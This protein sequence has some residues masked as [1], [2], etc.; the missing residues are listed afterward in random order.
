MGTMNNDV[1][2]VLATK[3]D[4]TLVAGGTMLSA[5]LAD[6]AF[7]V[8]N[9]ETNEALAAGAVAGVRTVYLAIGRPNGKIDK[10][11]GQNIQL[12][13]VTSYTVRNYNP[14]RPQIFEI[15][16]VVPACDTEYVIKL[17][18]TNQKI[19]RRQGY[20]QYTQNVVFKT[21]VCPTGVTSSDLN[22]WTRL[23][24]SALEVDDKEGTFLVEFVTIDAIT[25]AT[26]GVAAN[27]SAGDV[28]L[29]ADVTAMDVYNA[30]NPG[31]A[32]F[33]RPRVS[34][35]E[36]E[37]ENFAGAINTNYFNPRTTVVTPSLVLG[38]EVDG[39]ITNIQ[40]AASEEGSGYDIKQL[41]YKASSWNGSV[42]PYKVN[43]A[44]GLEK[45]GFVF[46]STET[47]TYAQ[48]ILTSNFE[49][50]SGWKEYSNPI[51]T[52]IAVPSSNEAFLTAL[53]GLLDD[54]VG[55]QGFDELADDYAAFDKDEATVESTSDIDDV[56]T[57]GLG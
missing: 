29:E 6:G 32:V 33:V 3:S 38:F 8:F 17:D 9:A 22:E 28:V 53:L 36:L 50:N 2:N 54:L 55:P 7:G 18:V 19:G 14:S 56:D 34:V 41:E 44:T 52:I 43:T 48:V 47:E 46:Y 23:F 25:I 57:D 51:T 42:G 1:F 4:S 12:K 30:N 26:H 11:A 37:K 45:R 40:D 20:N 21:A 39:A 16:G 15:T 35:L 27:Y 10:S 31:S 13:N 49:S 24:K 5:G